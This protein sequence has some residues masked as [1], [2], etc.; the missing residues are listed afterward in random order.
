MAGMSGAI[1]SSSFVAIPYFWVAMVLVLIFGITL[2][3]FPSQRGYYVTTD[4][5]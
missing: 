2:H 1:R 4:S 5:S 3:W